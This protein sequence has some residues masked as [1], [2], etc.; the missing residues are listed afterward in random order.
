MEKFVKDA[1]RV[2]DDQGPYKGFLIIKCEEC[3][4]VKGFCAKRETYSYKCQCGHETLLEKLRPLHLHCKCGRYF[5]YR[6]NLTEEK[7]AFP[8]LE[9]GEPVELEL[10]MRKTAYVTVGVRR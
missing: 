6:T 2:T 4:E 7:T 10:N 5:R 3:G 8:C 1:N 9:C